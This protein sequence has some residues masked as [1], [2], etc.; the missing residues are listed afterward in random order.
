MHLA[1]QDVD[2]QEGA[3]AVVPRGT[4]T[5]FG[6]RPHRNVDRH[7]DSLGSATAPPD[8][9]GVT[10]YTVEPPNPPGWPRAGDGNHPRAPT[11]STGEAVARRGT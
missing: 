10:C 3:A 8:R 4:F 5:Q 1:A 11:G 2:P 6:F 7:R 9:I